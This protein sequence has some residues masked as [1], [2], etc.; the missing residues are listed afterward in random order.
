MAAAK[1]PSVAKQIMEVGVGRSL[2]YMLANGSR[3]PGLG[4]AVRIY[5]ATGHKLGP[6]KD[7]TP[8]QIKALGS[9][10]AIQEDVAA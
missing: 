2:A 1:Q 8:A 6:L 4:L 3:A 7:A 9:L 5:R 10:P